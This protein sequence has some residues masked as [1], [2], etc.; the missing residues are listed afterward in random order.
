MIDY[1]RDFYGWCNEQANLLRQQRLSEIDLIHLIEEIESLGRSEK[2]ELAS[3]LRILISHLLKWQYQPQRQGN[4]WRNTIRIQRIDLL[5]LLRDNP[6]LV[7]RL[8]E[9]I[10]DNYALA[11]IDAADETL[12]SEATFPDACPYNSEQL[13]DDNFFPETVAED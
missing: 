9:E 12:L 2:R 4:S 1:E 13:L 7:P 3:R 5:K 6:S 10:N 8:S 11:R